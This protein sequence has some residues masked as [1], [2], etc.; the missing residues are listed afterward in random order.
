MFETCLRLV[1][2]GLSDG[3][4]LGVRVGENVGVVL[5]E[6]VGILLG[7]NVGVL[8]SR[9]TEYKFPKQNIQQW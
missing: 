3:E 4:K 5:G 7:E 8:L 2:V 1:V 9:F 6:D